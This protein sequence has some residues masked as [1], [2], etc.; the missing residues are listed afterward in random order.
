MVDSVAKNMLAPLVLRL[1]LAVIFIH[2]GLGKIN[3]TTNWGTKWMGDKQPAHVQG[4]VAWGELIGGIA[5]SVGFLA[6]LAGLGL[7]AIMGGA[8]YMVHGE[9]GFDL[10]KGGYEYNFAIIIMCV[11]VILLGAGTLS[12]DR[13]LWRKRQLSTGQ[14]PPIR[15]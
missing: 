2:H 14:P 3:E 11:A 7:A 13:V 5:M 15:Y 12:L 4:A 1:G 6:R 9:K 8:I 10:S